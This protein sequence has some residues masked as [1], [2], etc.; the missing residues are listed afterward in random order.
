MK[1][2]AWIVTQD[3]LLSV[4]KTGLAEL[5]EIEE[6]SILVEGKSE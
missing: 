3:G 6:R 1:N 5:S 2:R 4:S